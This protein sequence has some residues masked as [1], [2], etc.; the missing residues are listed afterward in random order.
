MSCRAICLGILFGT[1]LCPTLD[2]P[3]AVAGGA[4]GSAAQPFI[5]RDV[6]LFDG[7]ETTEHRSVLVD[8]G[9]IVRV[10]GP[11][12]GSPGARIVDGRGCT[13]LPGLIDSHVHI[14]DDVHGALAQA[15]AFGVTTELD[16][17]SSGARYARM[18]Q[19]RLDD[20]P[21]VAD[22]RSAGIGATAPGGHPTEMG[23][24]AIPTL[25]SPD[26]AQAFVDARVAEGSDY[27]KVI[28]DD[29]TGLMPKTFPTLD[30]ATIAAVVRAAHA[31][32]KLVVV[33]VGS[34]ADAR[35][36]LGAGADGLAHLFRGDHAS[37]DFGVFVAAH[38]AFV[39]PTLETLYSTC[40]RADGQALL[41]DTNVTRRL[42]SLW[43]RM[44]GLRWPYRPT[45]C[46]GTDD[47]LHQLVAARV[48][49]LAGTD[50][51][52]PGTAYG[53][54]LHGELALLV[55]DGLTPEAAL[56][57]ATSIPAHTFHLK[58]RGR[59]RPG[60]RADLLLVDDDPTRDILA[61]RR[62]VAVWKHGDPVSLP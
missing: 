10:G 21:D 38:H 61:T 48:P 29:L 55:A 35:M 53:A 43:Q 52:V 7:D 25:R 50:A 20:P 56:A 8:S 44:L 37:P 42:G 19:V 1:G 34:E 6:R 58:D 4:C 28:R 54:S 27:I 45:S 40:G 24:D 57:A 13:L 59:V 49:I 23:G 32:G 62:I 14:A 18:K 47:A 46:V 3:V 30:S 26:D 2:V 41:A 33:H 22:I 16:M 36:V 12:L 17:F 11:E 15:L 60:L 51:P 5:V 39:I 31:R 9:R